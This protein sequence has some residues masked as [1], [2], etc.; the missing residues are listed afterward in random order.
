MRTASSSNA[1]PGTRSS[2][3]APA[4]RGGETSVRFKQMWFAGS[5]SDVGGSYP[6]TE[7]RLSD[8]ALAWMVGE[9]E[10]L[11][12]PIR[13][14]RSVLKLYPDAAGGQH[15]ERKAAMTACPRWLIR[16]A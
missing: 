14:D 12:H 3:N 7:S 11:P 10:Y 13:I 5:H 9:A 2:R 15:N 8:I 6:E 16:L 4:R 1:C